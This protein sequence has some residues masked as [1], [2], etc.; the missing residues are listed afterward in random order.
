VAKPIDI[1]HSRSR[2]VLT[3]TWDDGVVSDLPAPYLRAWCPCAGCQGH[4]REIAFREP[5]PGI[6]IEGLF[7]MGAY[8]LGIRYSDGHDAGI[9]S[10][11]WLRQIAPESPP[12]GYKRGRFVGKKYEP[13]DSNPPL[14]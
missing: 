9:Y 7:E 12:E 11:A 6:T 2:N 13:T 14:E 1:A 5:P 3:V 10:W 4:G 8:A